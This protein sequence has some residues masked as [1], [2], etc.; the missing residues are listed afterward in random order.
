MTHLNELL[1]AELARFGDKSLQI[2][3][4]GTIRGDE[5]RYHANDGWSTLTFAEHVGLNGGRVTSIDLDVSTADRV[6]IRHGV[7]E[8]VDLVQGHSVDVLAGLVR[9]RKNFDV[10][11]LDSDNDADLILHEY[12]L[13]KRLFRSP[14][15]LLVDD[16]E[17]DSTGV[18]KGHKIVPQL[19][20]EGVDFRIL[21]RT[22]D[23]YSTG[24][25][26]CDV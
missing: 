7:R 12:F 25:L 9:A 10:I 11:L 4:T 5:D 17:L 8:F 3:E 1:A 2:L 18:V 21:T 20:A 6:L 22:G 16:V 24:V 14:G 26:V 23:G 19:T 15:L 13:A